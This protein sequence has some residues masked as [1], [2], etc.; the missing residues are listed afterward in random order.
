MG[1][2]QQAVSGA[3]PRLVAGIIFLKKKPFAHA[4][5]EKRT[6]SS[7]GCG[8]GLEEMSK[9]QD[10]GGGRQ[11]ESFACSNKG[12]NR[13][14]GVSEHGKGGESSQAFITHGSMVQLQRKQA[15]VSQDFCKIVQNKT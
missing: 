9:A 10:V 11:V 8:Y 7:R 14:C 12:E 6:L 4:R 15:T 1:G 2:S 5:R 13:R 3:S